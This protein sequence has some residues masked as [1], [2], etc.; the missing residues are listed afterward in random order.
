MR[1]LH[2][3]H[4]LYNW[5]EVVHYET[6]KRGL[7]YCNPYIFWRISTVTVAERFIQSDGNRG[8]SV[9]KWWVTLFFFF[10]SLFCSLVKRQHDEGLDGNDKAR[11]DGTDPGVC[12]VA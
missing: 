6:I 11:T 4:T 10:F 1:D 8:E 7:K 5:V 9:L 2:V 3:S 12:I